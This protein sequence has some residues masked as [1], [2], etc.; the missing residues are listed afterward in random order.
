MKERQK[1]K[2]IFE[3]GK[4][5]VKLQQGSFKAKV[6]KD[7]YEPLPDLLLKADARTDIE[8]EESFDRSKP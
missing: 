2:V 5:L 8:V 6:F 1:R 3:R 4:K 7:S